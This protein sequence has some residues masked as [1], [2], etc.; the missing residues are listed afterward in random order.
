MEKILA[1]FLLLLPFTTIAA[2]CDTTEL[3]KIEQRYID[4]AP[5]CIASGDYSSKACGGVRQVHSDTILEIAYLKDSGCEGRAHSRDPRVEKYNEFVDA[6]PDT[7]AQNSGAGNSYPKGTVGYAKNVSERICKNLI[8]DVV[9]NY[10]VSNL[11]LIDHDVFND[12][13]VNCVYSAIIPE[14]YGDRPAMVVA[15]FNTANSRFTVEIR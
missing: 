12:S 9:R 15:F 4:T 13:F 14:L 1:L 2:V 6:L 11:K 10:N 3:E 7:K 5:D 8:T